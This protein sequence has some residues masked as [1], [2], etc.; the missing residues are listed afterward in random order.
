MADSM[1][2]PVVPIA[3]PNGNEKVEDK[4]KEG[5]VELLCFMYY[6]CQAPALS[7]GVYEF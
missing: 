6:I 7:S 3:R 5:L 2:G 4:D 1:E